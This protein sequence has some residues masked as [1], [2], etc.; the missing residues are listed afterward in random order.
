MD[1][2]HCLP[3]ATVLHHNR[4]SQQNSMAYNN[5]SE[6]TQF[7]GAAGWFCWS[8][9][10]LAGPS[11][12][13]SQLG[14]TGVYMG[15]WVVKDALISPVSCAPPT[16]SASHRLLGLLLWPEQRQR[17]LRG[18]GS[19]LRILPDFSNTLL[20]RE[21]DS[22]DH[23]SQLFFVWLDPDNEGCGDDVDLRR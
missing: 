1:S 2:H 17:G 9:L 21:E 10:G 18:P 8:G 23:H 4:N 19:E 20:L 12:A 15:A 3:M 5:S 7:W 11:W 6:L 13:C 16:V 14:S 22:G